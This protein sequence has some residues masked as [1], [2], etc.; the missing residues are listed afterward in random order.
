MFNVAI[1]GAGVSGLTAARI[2]K[3]RYNVTVFERAAKPGGL[4][5]CERIGGSLFHTCGG[6]VFNT[7]RQ[8]V[9]EWFWGHF[10]QQ[11]DFVKAD[12]NS[13]VCMS[14]TFI[15]YPI[16]NHVYMLDADTQ[17]RFITDCLAIVRNPQPEPDNF[18]DFLRGRFGDTLYNLYF[19]PYNQK[20]WRCDLRNVPL[21]WLE[22]KLPMPTVQEMLFNNLN[23][24]EE[25]QFVHS[26][27]YYEK[28][29]GSQFIAD[30]LAQ[31]L[32][33]CYNADIS[34]LTYADGKWQLA[35]KLFDKVIYCGNLKQMVPALVGVDV[36]TYKAEVEALAYHG[37]TTVF[38]EIDAN[39]YSWIYLPSDQYACHRII[40]T[41][42]FSPSNNAP[43]L[44]AG[45]ITATVE[46]TDAVSQA[47]MLDSLARMPYHPMYISHVHNPYTYP[48]QTHSTRQ[49]IRRLK[50]D[51]ARS[52]FYFTG[53]FADWEYY[54]MDAAM[55]AAMALCTEFNL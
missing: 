7:K 22:G 18:E 17:Q 37:T 42:N 34:S 51:L 47:D 8:N 5:R 11:T 27:F 35:G 6:H 40:C 19:K 9:D 26:S 21:A 38:C 39:P 53:R 32:S 52:G 15:P 41:G 23:R 25:R 2:L 31:G 33:I 54:N 16:E 43:T 3:D 49:M 44:P 48:I 50:L 36:Q 45:R 20:V 10:N 29:G 24:V 14:Q 28:Q 55:A 4:I 30:T 12:R 1:I 46:F 13:V